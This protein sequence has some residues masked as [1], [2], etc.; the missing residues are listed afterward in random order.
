MK[1]KMETT[2]VYWGYIGT[3]GKDNGNYYNGLGFNNCICGFC[4]KR[5]CGLAVVL[6]L[7]ESNWGLSRNNWKPL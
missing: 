2:I 6:G 1:N 3:N 5:F 4:A 7:D